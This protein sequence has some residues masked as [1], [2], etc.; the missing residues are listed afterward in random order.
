METIYLSRRNLETLL[1]KLD[2]L[3]NGEDTT[4][5]IIKYSQP[6]IDAFKQTIDSVMIVAV[7]NDKYYKAQARSP[8]VVVPEDQPKLTPYGERE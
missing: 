1:S 7:P 3:E 4:C 2:R 5:A 6:N 8:G